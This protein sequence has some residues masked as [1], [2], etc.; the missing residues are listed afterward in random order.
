MDLLQEH[1]VVHADEAGQGGQHEH[2]GVDDD[3]FCGRV[4][5][6][7]HTGASQSAWYGD[8]SDW[9]QANTAAGRHPR[10]GG[11]TGTYYST[12]VLGKQASRDE[13][14]PRSNEGNEGVKGI[15]FHRE[16]TKIQRVWM[17]VEKPGTPSRKSLT[18]CVAF[19]ASR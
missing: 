4:K 3:R 12:N 19:V 9:N 16:A 18:S 5:R 14:S 2:G 1:G 13:Y 15:W 17:F 10:P 11:L 8:K 6:G 7:P